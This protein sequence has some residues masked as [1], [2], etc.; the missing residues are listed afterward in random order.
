[1]INTPRMPC[2]F[3]S[4]PIA[5]RVS[6]SMPTVMKSESHR[7]DS[8]STPSAA[9]WASARS[10]A[11]STMCS[12]TSWRSRSELTANIASTSCRKLRGPAASAISRR[13]AGAGL[14]GE[15]HDV[16]DLWGGVEPET[17]DSVMV[18]RPNGASQGVARPVGV[19]AATV[20]R[21]AEAT[22]G[23]VPN[24]FLVWLWHHVNVNTWGDDVER[25]ARDVAH[26]HGAWWLSIIFAPENPDAPWS[27]S[28]DEGRDND[29]TTRHTATLADALRL[30]L[31]E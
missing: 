30:R 14:A 29:A 7:P 3:G 26:A 10:R 28:I 17:G 6:S 19:S 27:V 22:E 15:E 24:R 12:R 13:V 21:A 20:L 4:A 23:D 25:L 9:Y 16:L 11:D 31:T 1:M 5:A 18:V 2:P 8:S